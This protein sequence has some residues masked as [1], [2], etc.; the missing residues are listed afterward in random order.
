MAAVLQADL[1]EGVIRV[2]APTLSKDSTK[3]K[4]EDDTT[5][6]DIVVRFYHS[7]LANSRRAQQLINRRYV[8]HVVVVRS[9]SSTAGTYVTWSSCAAAH[10]PPVRTLY[11]T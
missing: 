1:N 4:L 5:A 10:Q 9:S 11:V 3:I 7:Q 6:K 8:R 2:Q